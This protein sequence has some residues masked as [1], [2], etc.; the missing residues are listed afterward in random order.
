MQGSSQGAQG[1]PGR[2]SSQRKE[3]SRGDGGGDI[4]EA[5]RCWSVAIGSYSSNNH[6]VLKEDLVGLREL[7]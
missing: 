6:V 1:S 5:G 3:M 2:P 4:Q 7:C